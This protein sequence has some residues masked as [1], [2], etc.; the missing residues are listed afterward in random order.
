[1][2]KTKLGISVGLLG[3]AVYFCGVL[4]L[5]ALIIVAGYILLVEENI[6]LRKSAVK[7][8][9]IY[10]SFAIIETI[11][12]FGSEIFGNPASGRR[13][14]PHLRLVPKSSVTRY[15]ISAAG[16]GNNQ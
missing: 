10:V 14:S 5:L 7:A 12:S 15:E 1:M 9:V 6:W 13:T 8:V 11:F 3:A 4:S 2:Q 16:N